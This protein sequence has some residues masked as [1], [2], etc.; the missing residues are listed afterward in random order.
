MHRPQNKVLLFSVVLPHI[1]AEYWLSRHG[2]PSIESFCLI[3]IRSILDILILIIASLRKVLA[4][5]FLAIGVLTE[6]RQ[7]FC[8]KFNL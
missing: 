7:F 6:N 3:F 1:Y 2:I 5:A 4:A 8:H